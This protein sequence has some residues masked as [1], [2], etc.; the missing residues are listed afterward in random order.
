MNDLGFK[1]HKFQIEI[2]KKLVQT[3]GLRFNMLMLE[4]LESE[5]INY[6]LKQIIGFG[7][8][9]K[10]GNMYGLTDKGKDL[11]NRLGDSMEVVEKQ[12]KVGVVLSCVRESEDGKF[13]FLL[14][15]RLIQPYLGK[16]G[17]LTG[18]VRFGESVFDTA[19]RELLEET[20]LEAKN[21]HLEKV[22]RKMRRRDGGEYI[23]DVIFY[24][25]LVTDFS[26]AFISKTSVQENFWITKDEATKEDLYDDLI[27]RESLLPTPLI[28][29]E[30]DGVAQ[31]Y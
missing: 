15:K 3:K 10:E 30:N 12:P 6:H 23:Q 14:S 24:S 8:V 31:G 5:H 7:L 26:G 9:E 22:Y 11:M 29:E 4:G 17:R 2:L 25:F 16:V 20:G 19:K 28:Y 13:E 27:L 1:L 21:F 18:K